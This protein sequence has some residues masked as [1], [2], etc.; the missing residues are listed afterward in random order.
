MFG[1][2]ASSGEMAALVSSQS[3]APRYPSPSRSS[4]GVADEQSSSTPL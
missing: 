3:S 2:S 4:S 1:S